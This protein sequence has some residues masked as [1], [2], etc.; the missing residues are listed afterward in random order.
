[1][2]QYPDAPTM[3]EQG[4]DLVFPLWTGLYAPAGTPVVLA[5]DGRVLVD[6]TGD[7]LVRLGSAPVL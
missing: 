6:P 5:A 3:R 4:H 2:P 1:M 7:D